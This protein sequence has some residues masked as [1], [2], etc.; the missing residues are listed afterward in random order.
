MGGKPGFGSSNQQHKHPV[1][2]TA[3]LAS[4]LLEASINENNSSQVTFT[5]PGQIVFPEPVITGTD[6]EARTS[7][8]ASASSNEDCTATQPPDEDCNKG[9]PT[10]ESQHLSQS[11]TVTANA[12]LLSGS[13]QIT[14]NSQPVKDTTT[15][16]TTDNTDIGV[17]ELKRECF[18]SVAKLGD[19]T[20]AKYIQKSADTKFL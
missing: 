5:A 6:S 14:D 3:T 8:N 1:S 2:S 18:V 15:D 7:N 10:P 11:Q 17:L 4:A 9:L 19:K 16:P 20:I 12:N 13:V